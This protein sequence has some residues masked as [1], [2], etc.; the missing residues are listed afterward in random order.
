MDKTTTLVN[1]NCSQA[2]PNAQTIQNILAFSRAYY[3]VDTEQGA[4]E[5]NQN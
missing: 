1:E 3:C 5:M 2:R 4:F